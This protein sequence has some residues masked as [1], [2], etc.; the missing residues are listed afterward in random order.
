MLPMLP[1]LPML[2]MLPI[3]ARPSPRRCP[4]SAPPFALATERSVFVFSAAGVHPENV[5]ASAADDSKENARA[6]FMGLVVVRGCVRIGQQLDLLQ[7]GAIALSLQPQQ[8]PPPDP[9]LPAPTAAPASAGE[10]TG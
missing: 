3:I 4:S 7:R 6:V 10:L 9:A 1:V 2:P 8:H 5:A